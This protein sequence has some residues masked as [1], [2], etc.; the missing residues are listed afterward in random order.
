MQTDPEL[1]PIGHRWDILTC[2]MCG[3][4]RTAEDAVISLAASNIGWDIPR[5]T[6]LVDAFRAEMLRNAAMEPPSQPDRVEH[7]MRMPNG[8]VWLTACTFPHDQERLLQQGAVRVQ[9]T[10]RSGPWTEA[11]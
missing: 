6:Q 8:D 3:A 1:C 11:D 4:T 5:A 9:R 10:I 7:G 2:R